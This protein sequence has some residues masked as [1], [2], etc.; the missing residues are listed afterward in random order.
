VCN[1]LGLAVVL[2]PLAG[3]GAVLT[4]VAKRAVKYPNVKIAMDHIGFPRPEVLPDT[5]GLTP[6]HYELAKH[7][8]VYYKLTNFLVSEME[9]GAKA[10]NKPMV[11]LKPFVEHM[12]QTFGADH[13][14]WGSDFGNVEVDDMQ[15]TK[16]M[17]AATAGLSARDR[18]AFFYD[19]AKSVFVPGGRG[20]A[21]A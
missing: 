19:T 13:L 18:A 14:S 9:A 10:A 17:I 7:K 11:A 16:N 3:G 20:K 5:F 1:D 4:E 21:R 15:Y 6:E 12:V 8:N 2:M